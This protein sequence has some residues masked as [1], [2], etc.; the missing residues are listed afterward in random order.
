MLLV[1]MML[2]MIMNDCWAY[3]WW[4][5]LCWSRRGMI[6]WEGNYYRWVNAYFSYCREGTLNI[7]LLL[8]W[9]VVTWIHYVIVVDEKACCNPSMV[10]WWLVPNP[11]MVNLWF[12]QGGPGSWVN[13]LMMIWYYMHISLVE[14]ESL[15]S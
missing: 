13:Q 6:V 12:E 4:K 2:N 15:I 8:H 1:I 10:G 5:T 14:V 9:R 7:M 11:S 3:W